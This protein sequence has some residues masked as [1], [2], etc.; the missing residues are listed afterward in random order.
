MKIG[1]TYNL[2]TEVNF[3][4]PSMP[5]AEDM[6]EEFDSPE[7]IEAICGTLKEMGHEVVML[8]FGRKMIDKIM[9]DKVDFVFN[10]AEGYVGRAREAQIPA[11]LEMLNIPYSGPGPLA[12]T[13]TLDKISAKK[14]AV[15]S[16]VATPPYSVIWPDKEFSF[17]DITFPAILKLAYEGSSKGL[18][19]NS[20]VANED[21]FGKQLG[22]LKEHYVEQ[23]VL[24]EKFIAGREFA[25]G[26]IG[27]KNPEVLEIMEIRPKN[28][29]IKNFIYS[30]EVKRNYMFEVDYYCPPDI[31]DSLKKKLES[32]ALRLFNAFDCRDICRFDFRVD[33]GETPYFLEANPL[34]G[35]NPVSGDIVI[36]SRL[37]GIEYNRLIE[38]IMK[39]ALERY[40]LVHEHV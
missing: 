21:E 8:G 28:G 9:G 13:V 20:K 10:I 18:R 35:L 33:E 40:N 1:L 3:W 26:I 5:V 24:A 31:N 25:V 27:N 15:I 19:R 29:N 37:Q 12:A 11:L 2:K 32:A 7:T 38:L 17:K 39:H 23:P 6:Y 14:I 36:M 4:A 30:L 22:W 34:P 16:D